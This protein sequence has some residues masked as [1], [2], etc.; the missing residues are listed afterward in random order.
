MGL[1]VAF[2]A[3][4]IRPPYQL[5]TREEALASA[6]ASL[7]NVDPLAGPEVILSFLVEC[8]RGHRR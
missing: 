3:G 2:I 7:L 6:S 1:V 5:R 8:C 4:T